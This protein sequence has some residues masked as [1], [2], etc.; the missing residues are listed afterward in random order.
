VSYGFIISPAH[1]TVDQRFHY[2]Y[3]ATSSNLFVPITRVTP[4]N[5]TQFLT[6]PLKAEYEDI[7]WLGDAEDLMNREGHPITIHQC[8]VPPFTLLRL[9]P[10]TP[11]RG[12]ANRDNYSRILFFC[13]ID[14][15][16]YKVGEKAYSTKNDAF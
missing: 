1:G 8:I 12:I 13:T 4:L 15:A 16:H 7:Q 10:S 9:R 14:T 11:H 2:D 3:T 6:E 5:A